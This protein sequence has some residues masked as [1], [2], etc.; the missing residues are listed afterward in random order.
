MDDILQAQAYIDRTTTPSIQK[1]IITEEN[2]K[3]SGGGVQIPKPLRLVDEMT[4]LLPILILLA[5]VIAFVAGY[6]V[7]LSKPNQA[8]ET[9]QGIEHQVY[10]PRSEAPPPTATK[11]RPTASAVMHYRPP[12]EIRKQKEKEAEEDLIAEA[13]NFHLTNKNKGSFAA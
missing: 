1:P 11:K 2:P 7:G 8:A 4:V 3:H 6:F 10:S 12:Q 13:K 5:I 9:E